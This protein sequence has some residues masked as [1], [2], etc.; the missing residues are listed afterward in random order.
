MHVTWL[1]EGLDEL[2]GITIF[3]RARVLLL[4]TE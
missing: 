1:I 4:I 3:E 2:A